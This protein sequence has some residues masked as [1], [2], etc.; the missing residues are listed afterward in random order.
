MQT[1][2]RRRT[3]SLS[4]VI[5]QHGKTVCWESQ[6]KYL[7]SIL[8]H[9]TFSN[10]FMFSIL[11]DEHVLSTNSVSRTVVGI[12]H[13]AGMMEIP[14]CEEFLIWWRDTKRNTKEVKQVEMMHRQ[15]QSGRGGTAL[16]CP[17]AIRGWLWTDGLLK[18]KKAPATHRLWAEDLRRGKESAKVLEAK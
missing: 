18:D 14:A 12:Q 5:S 2:G 8:K 9:L 15:N 1:G 17:D 4:P 10:T 7:K 6:E 13:T 3:W 16:N 11:F